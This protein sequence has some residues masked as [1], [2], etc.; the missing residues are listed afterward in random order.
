[1]F[2]QTS[3]DDGLMSINILFIIMFSGQRIIPIHQ[4]T[5]QDEYNV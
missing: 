1:M 4:A 5:L 3:E 2:V